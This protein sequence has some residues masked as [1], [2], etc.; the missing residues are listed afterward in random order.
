M[1]LGRRNEGWICAKCGRSY[2]PFVHECRDCNGR[3]MDASPVPAPPIDGL[4]I[5]S[6]AGSRPYRV[7]VGTKQP[8]IQW[9]YTITSGTITAPSDTTGWTIT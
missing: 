3:D 7:W 5:P 8:R 6:T 1:E 9:P 4:P 2:A